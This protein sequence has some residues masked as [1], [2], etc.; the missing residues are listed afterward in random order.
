MEGPYDS[1]ALPVLLSTAL[2]VSLVVVFAGAIGRLQGGGPD[3]L[4]PPAAAPVPS[5]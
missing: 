1:K 3:N 5:S 4:P 2:I